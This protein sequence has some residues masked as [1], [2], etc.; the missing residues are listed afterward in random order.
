MIGSTISLAQ[1]P[2]MGLRD[3]A[4]ATNEDGTWKYPAVRRDLTILKDKSAKELFHKEQM[5]ALFESKSDSLGSEL[6]VAKMSNERTFI[7]N[8][9]MGILVGAAI[10]ILI[11]WGIGETR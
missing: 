5:A 1:T 10:T 9:E 2:E 7:D 6:M 4:G 8:L 11:S 3:F